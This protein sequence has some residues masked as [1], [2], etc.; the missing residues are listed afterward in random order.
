MFQMVAPKLCHIQVVF[1]MRM[2]LRHTIKVA[3]PMEKVLGRLGK[4]KGK[5]RARLGVTTGTVGTKELDGHGK[6]CQQTL[7]EQQC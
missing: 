4:A 1:R 3:S 5:E 2:V 7:Q 6:K